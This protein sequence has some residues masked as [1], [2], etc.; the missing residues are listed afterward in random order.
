M[1]E[2]KFFPLVVQGGSF[3]L[4]SFITFWVL[5]WIPK[6][7]QQWNQSQEAERASRVAIAEASK[8]AVTEATSSFSEAID[9]V[10]QT[11]ASS[12]QEL[13]KAH[14][15][16]ARYEREQC[17]SHSAAIM[18][19]LREQ[20]LLLREHHQMAMDYIREQRDRLI[21]GQN[22]RKASNEGNSGL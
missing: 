8:A 4:L 18:E 10:N 6:W 1:E 19:S 5:Y 20:T 9:K 3:A 2:W 15:E 13:I 22:K 21:I 17:A 14:R 7:G 12:T 11:H 16:E